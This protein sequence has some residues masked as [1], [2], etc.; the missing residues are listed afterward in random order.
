MFWEEQPP[1]SQIWDRFAP[2]DWLF[3]TMPD[4]VDVS[5]TIG[6]NNELYV[7][8]NWQWQ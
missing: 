3:Y 4:T 6:Q 7:D 8:Q 2:H 1:P 5:T